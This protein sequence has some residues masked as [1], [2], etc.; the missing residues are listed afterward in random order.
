MRTYY[1]CCTG[2]R[3]S[4]FPV[5]VVAIFDFVNSPSIGKAITANF[6]NYNLRFGD[7]NTR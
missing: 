1:N 5:L 6:L 7:E 2:E 4:D 3:E